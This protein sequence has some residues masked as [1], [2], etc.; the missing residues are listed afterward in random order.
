[1][2]EERQKA[3]PPHTARATIRT[4]AIEFSDQLL[5]TFAQAVPLDVRKFGWDG[6]QL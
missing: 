1:M 6:S 3:M 5:T 2:S 4:L